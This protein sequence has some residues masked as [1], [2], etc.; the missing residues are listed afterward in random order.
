M[1]ERSP[2]VHTSEDKAATIIKPPHGTASEDASW[3]ENRSN[4]QVF[5]LVRSD[6]FGNAV[7]IGI[8]LARVKSSVSSGS[9]WWPHSFFLSTVLCTPTVR[10]HSLGQRSFSYAAPAVWDTLVRNQVIQHPL[11]LQIM[12]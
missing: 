6:L 9:W 3:P 10:T 1:V 2:K 7:Y 11:I 4:V 8:P 5:L 12:T